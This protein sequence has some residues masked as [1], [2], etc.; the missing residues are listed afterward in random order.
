MA[1]TAGRWIKRAGTWIYQ[2]IPAGGGGVPMPPEAQH[3]AQ[4]VADERGDEDVLACIRAA[5][6][7][8]ADSAP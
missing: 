3:V 2:M 8:I 4:A 7:T 1:R 5:A 6:A